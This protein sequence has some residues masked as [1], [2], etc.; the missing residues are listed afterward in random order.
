MILRKIDHFEIGIEEMERSAYWIR[1]THVFRDDEYECSACGCT[2]TEPYPICPECGSSMDGS[3]SDLNWI[4][5]ME[6]LD[7]MLED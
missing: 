3:K 1:H 5:E 4:D 7:M 2:T 6:E